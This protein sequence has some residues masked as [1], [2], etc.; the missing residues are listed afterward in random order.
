MGLKPHVPDDF[1]A[2]TNVMIVGLLKEQPELKAVRTGDYCRAIVQV[3][4][5]EHTVVCRDKRAKTI[6]GYFPGTPLRITGRLGEEGWKTGGDR[7]EH[8]RTI[9]EADSVKSLALSGVTEDVG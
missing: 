9:I 3:G 7:K 2:S 5:Q 8:Y 1:K 6:S 4:E